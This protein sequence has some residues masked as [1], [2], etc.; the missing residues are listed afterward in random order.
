MMRVGGERGEGERAEDND[1]FLVG[2][3]VCSRVLFKIILFYFRLVLLITV[4]RFER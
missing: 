3:F 1:I 4:W 2:F